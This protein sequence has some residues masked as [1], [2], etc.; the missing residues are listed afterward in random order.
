MSPPGCQKMSATPCKRNVEESFPVLNLKSREQEPPN[1][2]LIRDKAF[3]SLPEDFWAGVLLVLF[4]VA[5]PLGGGDV[6]WR[7]SLQDGI[8][9]NAVNLLRSGSQSR[10]RLIESGVG[11]LSI[12]MTNVSGE[13]GADDDPGHSCS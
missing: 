1:H 6:F 7:Q 5:P 9:G 8:Y 12:S 10:A 3:Y 4:F 13:Q 11:S 2:L